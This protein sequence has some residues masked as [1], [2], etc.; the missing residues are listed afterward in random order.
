MEKKLA[1]LLEDDESVL[2]LFVAFLEMSGYEVI[3]ATN[4][5]DAVGKIETNEI[6]LLVSDLGVHCGHIKDGCEEK[7]IA[8][9][10][11]LF[12]IKNIKKVVLTSGDHMILKNVVSAIKIASGFCKTDG[13]EAFMSLV[14]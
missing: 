6:Y 9:L 11:R 2:K 4:P 13:M 1:V 14:R 12:K 7:I 10:Q 8:S 5:E 3:A